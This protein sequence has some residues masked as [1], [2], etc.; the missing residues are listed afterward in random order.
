MLLWG[1]I[2]YGSGP[3]T[4]GESKGPSQRRLW[5]KLSNIK[6]KMARRCSR[7]HFSP[8][9]TQRSTE[10]RGKNGIRTNL[11]ENLKYLG[12]AA[13]TTLPIQ[14]S[15]PNRAGLFGFFNHPQRLWGWTD[16]T[17]ISLVKVDPTRGRRTANAG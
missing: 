16:G 5:P 15:A 2:I 12:K 6:H 4:H 17:S 10:K 9:Q 8:R 7:R 14:D 3:L 11:K 1:P 13:L